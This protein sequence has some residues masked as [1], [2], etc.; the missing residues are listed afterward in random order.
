L[1]ST[2]GSLNAASFR[3]AAPNGMSASAWRSPLVDSSR[4]GSALALDP[5]GDEG[6]WGTLRAALGVE[7]GAETTAALGQDWLENHY[8]WI[9][10]KLACQQRCFAATL[11]TLG[12]GPV[13]VVSQLVGRYHREILKK[14]RSVL[15]RIADAADMPNVQ[16]V[17]CIAAARLRDGLVEL[18][19]GWHSAWAKCDAP[20]TR[21]LRRGKLPIGIKLR[22][23]GADHATSTERRA[24]EESEG[25]AAED[26]A[27]DEMARQGAVPAVPSLLLHANGVRR[28]AWDARLGKTRQ[29]VFRVALGS[30]IEGGG[31]APCVHVRIERRYGPLALE[32]TLDSEEG[33]Q[34]ASTWYTEAGYVAKLS[35]EAAMSEEAAPER[36]K[37]D[38]KGEEAPAKTKVSWLLRLV[39]SDLSG[40]V[41]GCDRRCAA[42]VWLNSPEQAADFEEGKA[43][44]VAGPTLKQSTFHDFTEFELD[45]KI[46]GWEPIRT[47]EPFSAGALERRRACVPLHVVGTMPLGTEMNCAGVLLA[48]ELPTPAEHGRVLRQLFIGDASG[49]ILGVRWLYGPTDPMPRLKVGE[50]I[51]LRNLVLEHHTRF[52]PPAGAE[53]LALNGALHMCSCTADTLGARCAVVLSHAAERSPHFREALDA[54]V[55]SLA[56][57]A[58][59]RH[60][61]ESAALAAAAHEARLSPAVDGVPALAGAP[62]LVGGVSPSHVRDDEIRAS[63]EARL[64]SRG[65]T[66]EQLLASA[67]SSVLA[68][69]GSLRRVLDAMRDEGACYIVPPTG[70]FRLM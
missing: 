43:Y 23:F 37:G 32:K 68:D 34:K 55:K 49:I 38:E 27:G 25:E 30:L 17:L 46:Q 2:I 70:E 50:P 6:Y 14:N 24:G 39:V 13:A 20:L 12:F 40:A 45:V 5:S 4:A 66:F 9:V 65:A 41:G 36:G 15:L 3:F 53:H 48:A 19:D 60:Y 54:M 44:R 8:R 62:T 33:S 18:T 11:G 21:Q 59:Q 57:P 69:A 1:A 47:A 29:R 28:A 26:T 35:R 22:I 67:N 56:N 64:Y 16:M 7:I 61:A 42:S 10:W 52:I 58:A 63:V 51:A 31:P